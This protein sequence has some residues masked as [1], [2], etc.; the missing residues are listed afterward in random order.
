MPAS[1]KTSAA[2]ASNAPA[3]STS[4]ISDSMAFLDESNHERVGFAPTTKNA[5][6]GSLTAIAGWPVHNTWWIK[7][8][9][10]VKDA[11]HNLGPHASR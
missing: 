7:C 2:Q 6:G 10:G 11:F 3:N 9:I 1:H 8:E 5:W 4:Q